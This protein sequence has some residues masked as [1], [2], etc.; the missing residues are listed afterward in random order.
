MWILGMARMQERC[1]ED[2]KYR[3]AAGCRI[4]ACAINCLASSPCTSPSHTVVALYA[5]LK[6]DGTHE[7]I[8]GEGEVTQHPAIYPATYPHRGTE[9]PKTLTSM[10]HGVVSTTMFFNLKAG[11][12][13]NQAAPVSMNNTRCLVFVH[14]SGRGLQEH[15]YT[16]FL[17]KRRKEGVLVSPRASNI[18]RYLD[19]TVHAIL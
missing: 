9:C 11:G 5:G 14:Q 12:Q 1:T 3:M 6:H 16:S 19:A 10:R 18:D 17:G 2:P 4:S 7:C 8:Q 15:N 13:Y